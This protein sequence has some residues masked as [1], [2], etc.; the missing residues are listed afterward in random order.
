MFTRPSVAELRASGNLLLCCGLR[1]RLPETV[2]FTTDMDVR[3][4]A[5]EELKY[6]RN[7]VVA[8]ACSLNPAPAKSRWLEQFPP[9]R[10]VYQTALFRTC[11]AVIRHEGDPANSLDA[12][13]DDL[14]GHLYEIGRCGPI[15]V[16]A[17]RK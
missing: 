7:A 1:R 12:T 13:A 11:R 2:F 16:D 4:W 5:K 10:E 15:P 14:A 6:A 9:F 8:S 17:A 3:L